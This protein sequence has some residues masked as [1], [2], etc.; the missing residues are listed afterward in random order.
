MDTACTCLGYDCAI[1][2]KSFKKRGVKKKNL[3]SSTHTVL[4]AYL[5]KG[6]ELMEQKQKH[7]FE[8]QTTQ[9]WSPL[10]DLSG[11]EM[12]TV[13]ANTFPSPV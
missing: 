9:Q 3:T 6:D 8:L 5:G 11:A 2:S 13:E 12:I 4:K 10:A 7:L 1:I